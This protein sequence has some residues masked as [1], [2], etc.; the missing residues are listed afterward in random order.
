[1]LCCPPPMPGRRWSMAPATILP[2]PEQ[3]RLVT[4]S[5][6]GDTIIGVVATT[7]PQAACPTCGQLAER[8]HSRYLRQVADLPWQG[9][10][11]GL[12]VHVRRFF[13][14]QRTCPQAIFTERLPGIVAPY[15]RRT[16][17]LAR[18]VELV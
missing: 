16:L 8:I 11:F 17:R 4:L 1:M 18:L 5:V 9:V 15:G 2:D 3:L 10:A 14:D 7:A 12:R 13:C 6:Q